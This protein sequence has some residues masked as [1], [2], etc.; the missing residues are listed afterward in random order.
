MASAKS[1]IR[2]RLK[3]AGLWSAFVARRDG[4]KTEGLGPV[5]SSNQAFP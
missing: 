5:G 1:D 3:A 4:L 2:D